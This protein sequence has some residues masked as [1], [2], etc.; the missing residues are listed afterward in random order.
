M[1]EELIAKYGPVRTLEVAADDEETVFVKAYLKELTLPVI[2]AAVSMLD[3]DPLKAAKMLFDA[4]IILEASDPLFATD[5][6]VKHGAYNEVMAE[7]FR[8]RKGT[9][10][11]DGLTYIIEVPKDDEGA[12][13]FK[14]VL[15]KPNHTIISK[16][17]TLDST[18]P[19]G[20]AM[21][22]LSA[23]A[24]KDQTD[25]EFF[26]DR[27]VILGSVKVLRDLMKSRSAVIKKNF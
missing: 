10:R 9:K 27:D 13:V 3:K 24:I 2:S 12:E 21:L 1:L 6:D 15:N 18:D 19:I 5:E 7:T 17:L 8:I 23:A 16:A 11:R 25:P 4:C 20:A 22:I 26:N 14:A